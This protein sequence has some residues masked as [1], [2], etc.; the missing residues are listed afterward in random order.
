MSNTQNDSKTN[1]ASY[2]DNQGREWFPRITVRELALIE[3]RRGVDLLSEALD[4]ATA[5]VELGKDAKPEAQ[6]ALVLGLMRKMFGN[7][8]ALA[9][10]MFY[11]VGGS[12][13]K[14]TLTGVTSDGRGHIEH[15]DIEDFL[16]AHDETVLPHA[17]RA[18]GSELVRFFRVITDAVGDD[19]EMTDA[20]KSCVRTVGEM[21]IPT[22]ASQE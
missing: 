20:V 18:F 8:G 2:K 10:M 4:F 3:Q 1:R 19:V 16:R 12:D 13:G 17:A 6:W 21:C 9:E 22:Q 14:L 15:I 11:S 5:N 7:I